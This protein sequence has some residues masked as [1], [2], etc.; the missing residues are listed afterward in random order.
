[1]KLKRLTEITAINGVR[2]YAHW[3]ALVIET[4][5]LLGAI[6]RQVEMIAA[7]SAYFSASL[8]MSADT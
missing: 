7:W 8:F 1:M 5:M 3:S 2:V 4:L 6:E